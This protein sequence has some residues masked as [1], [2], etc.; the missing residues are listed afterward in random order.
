MSQAPTSMIEATLA[1]LML[2]LHV[3]APLASGLVSR[4]SRAVAVARDRLH[5]G[6]AEPMSIRELARAAERSEFHLIRTFRREV[7]LPPHA[8]ADQVRIAEAKEMLAQQ[9]SLA[10]IAFTLGFCDQSHFTRAFKRSS[11]VPPG[12]WSRMIHHGA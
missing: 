2:E 9:R 12:Q 8:Y 11:L 5:S 1:Q 7:G 4:S 3:A 10:S 6:I